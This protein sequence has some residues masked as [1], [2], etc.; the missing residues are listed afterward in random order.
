MGPTRARPLPLDPQPHYDLRRIG[1]S[2]RAAAMMGVWAWKRGLLLASARRLDS[3]EYGPA[4]LQ[5]TGSGPAAFQ[6][7]P[8]TQRYVYRR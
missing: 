3:Y 4:S 1:V 7:K 6:P 2:A 5:L 8:T